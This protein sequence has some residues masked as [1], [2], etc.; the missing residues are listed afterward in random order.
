MA[1]AD[2]LARNWSQWLDALEGLGFAARASVN[3]PATDD[4]LAAL[5]AA[6]GLVLT[7]EVRAFYRLANGQRSLFRARSLIDGKV[8][9]ELFTYY[10]FHDT[11]A[12]A[13]AWQG[14]KHIADHSGPDGMADFSRHVTT[15]QPTLVKREYWLPGWL[16]FATDGGG[17]S[18]TFDFAP[19]ANG[20]SG[21]IIVIGSDEDQRRVLAPGISVYLAKLVS[22]ARTPGA[23]ELHE[24]DG[25][26]HY[27][28][29]SLR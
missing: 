11:V 1:M 20:T 27:D 9:I 17:N 16:P 25:D 6:T 26:R 7:P 15:K 8:P 4:A 2:D 29:P 14:W 21:Q 19:E 22:A 18:L 23:L 12:A 28:I 13:R 24:R 3:P 10:E 5:E